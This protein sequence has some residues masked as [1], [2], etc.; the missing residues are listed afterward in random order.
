VMH[1]GNSVAMQPHCQGADTR[2][3]TGADSAAVMQHMS[4]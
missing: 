2:A 1:L 4:K 3:D